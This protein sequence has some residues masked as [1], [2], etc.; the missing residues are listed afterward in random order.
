M[1]KRLPFSSD[2][3][4]NKQSSTTVPISTWDARPHFH[5]MLLTFQGPFLGQSAARLGSSYSARLYG[6]NR[7]YVRHFPTVILLN[8][9]VPLLSGDPPTTS[10]PGS[11]LLPLSCGELQ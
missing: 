2:R 11:R 5:G 9:E 7:P 8:Y 6:F 3:P 4:Q 10:V 1:S